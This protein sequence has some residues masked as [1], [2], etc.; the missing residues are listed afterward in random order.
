MPA[1]RWSSGSGG[2]R[3]S[4]GSRARTGAGHPG[5]AGPD[6]GRLRRATRARWCSSPAAA[7]CLRFRAPEYET[8]PERGSVTWRID[9]GLLVAQRG[10]RRQRLCCGSWS[11]RCRPTR[12]P[13][14]AADPGAARGPQLL[15][16]ASRIWSLRP[17][18]RLALRPDPAAN[19]RCSSATRSCVPSPASTSASDRRE[20]DGDGLGAPGSGTG[21]REDPGH[22]SD[23]VH[24]RAG[25]RGACSTTASTSAASSV[26]LNAEGARELAAS[27]GASSQ[28]PT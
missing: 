20:L 18:G 3:T 9:R 26:S 11:A 10:P 2:P 6:P 7:D 19:P 16:V 27:S 28:W 1:G 13:A 21:G 8:G 4:S 14:Y 12:G 23:G 15:P 17:T 25:W 5:H 22:R 24:R